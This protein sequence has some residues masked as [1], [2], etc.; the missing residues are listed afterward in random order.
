VQV[1]VGRDPRTLTHEEFA[2]LGHSRLSAIQSLRARCIDCCAGSPSEVRRCVSISC[3]SWPFR[4][5]WD[6]WRDRRELTPEQKE[7]QIGHLNRARQARSSKAK[8]E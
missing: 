2:S 1:E 3:P 8:P 4:M 7:R 6:P 5:G